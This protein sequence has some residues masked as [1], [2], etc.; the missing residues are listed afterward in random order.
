V[1]SPD[2]DDLFVIS[3]DGSG[4]TNITNTTHTSEWDPSWYPLSLTTCVDSISPLSQSF[5]AD[6]GTGTVEVTAGSTCSWSAS[7]NAIW[8]SIT[9]GSSSG[10]GVVDYSVAA[11]IST[12]PRTATLIVAGHPFIATQSGVPV[13]ITSASVEGTRLLVIGENFDPSAV[14]LLNGEEQRTKND[15]QN[16]RTGLICKKAGKKVK[17]GDKLQVRN[18]DNTLSREFI[19]AGS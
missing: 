2:R 12:R 19:F 17:P 16:P 10:N 3:I 13:R 7:S 18:A 1:P 14:I 8:I 9:P 11:N 6:G 4:L 15:P 5:D